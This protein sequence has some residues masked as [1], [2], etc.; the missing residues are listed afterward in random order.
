MA[1][2]EQ[3]TQLAAT[4]LGDKQNQDSPLMKMVVQM[5]SQSSGPGGG[6]GLNNLL[7]NFQKNGLGDIV[8]TW[9]GTGKNQAISPQ[10]IQ[11]GLGQETLQRMAAQ[12]GSTVENTSNRLADLLPQIVD[13][14]TP[15]GEI[16][17]NDSLSDVLN[18]LRNKFGA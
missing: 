6:N 10:Q 3:F 14:L 15:G 16:P 1:L 9:I 8:S 2:F 13:K 17:D 11:Q 18:V 4:F 5:F 12:T 7:Q